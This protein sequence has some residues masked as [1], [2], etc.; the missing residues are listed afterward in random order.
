MPELRLDSSSDERRKYSQKQLDLIDLNHDRFHF[1]EL[2][3]LY[4]SLP[5]FHFEWFASWDNELRIDHG[6]IES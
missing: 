4:Q 6:T 5:E 3:E 2:Q 1:V